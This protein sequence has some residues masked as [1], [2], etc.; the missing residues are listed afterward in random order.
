MEY[1]QETTANCAVQDRQL[2]NIADMATCHQD[3]EPELDYQ[4]ELDM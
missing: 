4:L 2:E 1:L 3:P